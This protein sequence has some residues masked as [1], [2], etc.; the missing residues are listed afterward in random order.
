MV[1]CRFSDITADS[2][3]FFPQISLMDASFDANLLGLVKTTLICIIQNIRD[4]LQMVNTKYIGLFDMHEHES[5]KEQVKKEIGQRL[6]RARERMK[7]N[8]AELAKLVDKTPG[9]ISNY[10]LGVSLMQVAELP[11]FARALD[12]PIAYFFGEAELPTRE[13]AVDV[14]PDMVLTTDNGIVIGIVEAK[15]KVSGVGLELEVF[16]ELVDTLNNI[17]AL[18]DLLN[19]QGYVTERE[20]L[21]ALNEQL[22]D[23]LRM[24]LSDLEK[25]DQQLSWQYEVLKKRGGAKD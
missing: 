13:R 7:L 17:Q 22:H 9:A 11:T 19:E 8:Q 2:K 20:L 15:K 4:N 18:I 16:S 10:E 21:D 24:S 6:R 23:N 3:H 14:R 12:V 1:A 5:E 25:Y